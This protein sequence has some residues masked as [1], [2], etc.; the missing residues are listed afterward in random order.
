MNHRCFLQ[1]AAAWTLSWFAPASVWAVT[2][3]IDAERLKTADGSPMPAS[4]LVV[5]VASTTNTIFEGPTDTAFV[6]GDDIELFRWDLTAFASNGVLSDI[7]ASLPFTGD[8]NTGDPIQI[9]WFPT[10]DINATAPGPGTSYGQYRDGSSLDGSD[11]WVTPGAA[12][13]VRLRFFTDDATFLNHGGS[14]PGTA[15]LANFQTPDN[16]IA[17]LEVAPESLDFGAV[18]VG[19]SKN[20]EFEVINS[21]ELISI[22]NATAG[23]PF[24]VDGGSPFN[25]D[26]GQTGLVVVSFSPVAEGSFEG[27]VVFTSNGGSSSNAVSG[28]GT[29]IPT[30][31]FAASPTTGLV[32]LAVAFTN[33]TTG[34]ATGFSWNFGDGNGSAEVHPTH[35]YVSAGIFTV[36]LTAVGSGGS[37]TF[38]RVDYIVVDEPPPPDATPPS[39]VIASPT[40]NQ[41]FTAANITVEGTAADESGLNSVTVNGDA[42]NLIGSNWSKPFTLAE[43]TNAI[44]VIATDNSPAMNAATQSVHAIYS[45]PPPQ[46]TNAP[47]VQITAPTNGT[48]AT[49]RFIDITGFVADASGVASVVV[50][51]SRGGSVDATLAGADWI[52]SGMMLKLGTNKLFAV[53]TDAATNRAVDMV[54]VVRVNT[55]YVNTTLRVRDATV[56][57]RNGNNRDSA[58][59]TAVYNDASVDFNPDADRIEVLFGEMEATLPPGSLENF[60]Y[61]ARRNSDSTINTFVL[62]PNRRT[63]RVLMDRIHFDHVDPCLVAVALGA[64]DLGPDAIRFAIP[65]GATGSFGWSFGTQLPGFDLFFLEEARLTTDNFVLSGTIHI[66]SKPS[67]LDGPV[68]VGIGSFDETL[69]V[70]GWTHVSGDRYSFRA[71]PD[72]AGAVQ[73]MLLDLDTG[74][75]Y[76]RGRG[77]HL[78]FLVDNP[79]TDIRVE[80]GGFAASYAAKFIPKGA[81]FTY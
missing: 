58:E 54:T 40:E 47:V 20:L 1:L 55:N 6:T 45:P 67:P 14:N 38:T 25:V 68:C 11:S 70:E 33:L 75:W 69:P 76:L 15:G 79:T 78:S 31:N 28:V 51:N 60:R 18:S 10:L 22:G 50:T 5:L 19:Q 13:T 62:N 81:R 39:L 12:D 17:Q 4:G 71:P 9:Y 63:M 26:P 29:S 66:A 73:T 43:G 44:V 36:S 72:Y 49:E 2:F 57:L 34:N 30:A 52:A 48:V 65:P 21:G 23:G 77:A 61:R 32:P 64:S 37:N 35:T 59:F 46:D 56:T 27:K 8:W 80:I 3:T 74:N 41:V 7:T 42:A 16:R 53:A 24:S